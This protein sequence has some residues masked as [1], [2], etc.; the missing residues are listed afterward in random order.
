M[1]WQ[2]NAFGVFRKVFPDITKAINGSRRAARE[3]KCVQDT[4]EI[5]PASDEFFM[6]LAFTNLEGAW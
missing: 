5:G 6:G 4:S 3:N 1:R 2:D